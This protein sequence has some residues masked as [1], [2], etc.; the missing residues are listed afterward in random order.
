MHPGSFPGLR[1]PNS[2]CYYVDVV[3]VCAQCKG[4]AWTMEPRALT[5]G[6]WI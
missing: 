4:M 5:L 6:W 2:G 3:T 1:G